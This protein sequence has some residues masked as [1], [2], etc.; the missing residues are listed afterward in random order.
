M[1]SSNKENI[2][3]IQNNYVKP[4]S[5]VLQNELT[6][7]AFFGAVANKPNPERKEQNLKT[8]RSNVI[9]GGNMKSVAN[10]DKIV[11]CRE[12]SGGIS[13]PY[14]KSTNQNVASTIITTALSEEDIQIKEM[15][16][17]GSAR[18][19]IITNQLNKP[20]TIVHSS[21][22]IKAVV[23]STDTSSSLSD[24]HI[25]FSDKLVDVRLFSNSSESTATD[26]A[27][28]I[29]GGA[30]TNENIVDQQHILSL[31][32]PT[33]RILEGTDVTA[34][35]GDGQDEMEEEEDSSHTE[36]EIQQEVEVMAYNESQ[37]KAMS[38]FFTAERQS[39]NLLAQAVCQVE[40]ASL[41]G[42]MDLDIFH[43]GRIRKN[44]TKTIIK[45]VTLSW[46]LKIV[47]STT[48][49]NCTSI[50]NRLVMK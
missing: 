49:G 22:V 43:S 1:S 42:V 7:N 35:H 50:I 33:D 17:F 10:G 9:N 15:R 38:N 3:P 28:D 18:I 23:A 31:N 40:K 12:S 11:Q 16:L 44:I 45:P 34:A 32:G 46:L 30:E 26:F 48:A 37:I 5:L 27:N 14:Q 13:K 8:I 29:R 41:A 2:A 19:P 6:K 39:L 36:N 4:L 20:Q 25:T 21:N 24:K 47:D